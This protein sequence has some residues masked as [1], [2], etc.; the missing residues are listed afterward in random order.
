M[1]ILA[2]FQIERRC[3]LAHL[4]STINFIPMID[5]YAV[6]T[7]GKGILSYGQDSY[8]YTMRLSE[9]FVV[10]TKAV[11]FQGVPLTYD[12]SSRV[13]DPKEIHKEMWEKQKAKSI[14]I[15]PHDFILGL[16]LE[17]FNMPKNV[18]AICIGKS[19]YARCGIIVNVTPLEPSWRGQLV[20]EISNST[21]FPVKVYANEGIAQVIFLMSEVECDSAYDGKYQ[22]QNEIE[23][24]KV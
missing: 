7:T 3:K 21:N 24:P 19:T 17:H 10:P 12:I 5:P 4:H 14:I 16:S 6:H 2:D 18:L 20:I 23:L 8:G 15:P 9:E 13:I 1:G 22:D 11:T